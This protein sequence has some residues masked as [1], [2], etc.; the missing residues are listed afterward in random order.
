MGQ[1]NKRVRNSNQIERWP[2]NLAPPSQQRR[3]APG[4]GSRQTAARFLSMG[5]IGTHSWPARGAPF[6]LRAA[7][8]GA[9]RPLAGALLAAWPG[10]LGARA[11]ELRLNKFA[12]SSLIAPRPAANCSPLAALATVSGGRPS[13]WLGGANLAAPNNSTERR[14]QQ[15]AN[16]TLGPKWAP[17]LQLIEC[18]SNKTTAAV[19]LTLEMLL[20]LPA[21]SWP[22]PTPQTIGPNLDCLPAS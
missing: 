20:S 18:T 4:R 3:S 1:D 12:P 22:A 2:A 17:S 14:Q 5:V 8:R 15:G 7:I 13:V 11:V 19:H 9:Q 21:G 16:W 10:N 6:G